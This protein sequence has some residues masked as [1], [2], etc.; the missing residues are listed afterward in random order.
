MNDRSRIMWRHRMCRSRRGNRRSC[1]PARSRRCSDSLSARRDCIA[2]GSLS[3]RG[4]LQRRCSSCIQEPRT[5]CVRTARGGTACLGPGPLLGLARR[6]VC[7]AVLC[8]VAAGEAVV[9]VVVVKIARVA[10]GAYAVVVKAADTSPVRRRGWHKAK[11]ILCEPRP[12]LHLAVGV[13][14]ALRLAVRLGLRAQRRPPV[15]T[16]WHARACQPP[17]ALGVL[18][19][20]RKELAALDADKP[21]TQHAVHEGHCPHESRFV[22]VATD[23]EK[24]HSA[25]VGH[26]REEVGFCEHVELAEVKGRVLLARLLHQVEGRVDADDF[27][28]VLGEHIRRAAVRRADLYDHVRRS[29][30]RGRQAAEVGGLRHQHVA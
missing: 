23:V 10:L 12:A 6:A 5:R 7:G 26:A 20:G 17:T 9:T 2:I 30:L 28:A 11:G 27:R 13:V 3:R 14:V 22:A 1:C 19:R 4:G 25:P 16:A 24:A 15:H 21:G 8:D 18:A 29:Q